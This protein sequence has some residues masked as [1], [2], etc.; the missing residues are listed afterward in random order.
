MQFEELFC[1]R[2]GSRVV[3]G[4]DLL[5]ARAHTSR[6][7]SRC[8]DEVDERPQ[9]RGNETPSGVVAKRPQ[10]AL[11][12]WFK[13]GFEGAAVDMRAQPVLEQIDNAGTGDRGDSRK[14]DY[15]TLCVDISMCYMR[16]ASQE[17]GLGKH[18]G[19][20]GMSDREDWDFAS[21]DDAKAE[22][23]AAVGYLLKG[24][25]GGARGDIV[26]EIIAIV[27]GVASGLPPEQPNPLDDDVPGG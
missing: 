9:W 14:P 5:T 13:G 11:P 8:L 21:P 24:A 7:F 16:F 4:D 10:E 27:R 26:Q 2:Q 17:C 12:P 19:S 25:S 23:R 3:A 18:T 15:N 1:T 20:E 22:I 6:L